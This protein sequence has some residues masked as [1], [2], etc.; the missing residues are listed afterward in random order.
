MSYERLA[1][2]IKI[3][4]KTAPN[5][6]V[7]HPMECNDADDSGNPTDLTLKRY[8]KLA[9]GGA[10]IIT[11]ESLSISP[12]SRAR[13]HQLE[14]TERNIE[15]L[16]R[17]V[18]EMREFN[19]KPLIIFQINHSG[20]ISN[21]AFSQVVSYNPTGDPSVTILS[22]EDT[23][24]IKNRFVNA[25]VIA[26]QVGADGIDFKQCH[27]YFCGQLLR[28]ANTKNGR[29][30]GS[31]ENRTRFFRETADQIKKRV[32]DDAFIL[33]ARVS[34]YEGITGGM[35]TIGPEAVAEDLTESVAFARMIEASGFHFINISSGIPVFTGEICR[36][37]KNYPLGVYRHFTWTEAVKDTVKIPL[38]GTGYSYL[39]DGNNN[40]PGRNP[41]K[42]SLLYWAEKNIEDDNVDM[43]GIGR[44]SL[45]DPLFC[46]KVLAGNSDAISYCIACGGCSTLL[47]S[48]A[49]VG[50]TV[51][52][53]FY[54]EELRR[55]RQSKK[56]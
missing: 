14:I 36:P 1:S 6:W 11:V 15:G 34:M 22:D 31:F 10:G 56:D 29:F 27:G 51:H 4:K 39:R 54:K 28:P 12:Q 46:N 18:K 5:R 53:P 55:V 13:K 49:R 21:K 20:N 24:V 16:S 32:N 9:E 33:G 2:P 3:G 43:V 35:G 44:Q 42:K 48:Q 17:L 26:H 50:C 41:A 23:E 25:A 8:Q 47:V 30:G 38:I 40:L 52:D 37:T 7:N 19:N 45:A